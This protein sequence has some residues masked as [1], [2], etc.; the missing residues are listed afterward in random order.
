[1]SDLWDSIPTWVVVLAA[2]LILGALYVVMVPV[3]NL[4]LWMFLL[5]FGG[6]VVGGIVGL[7]RGLL[8][9]GL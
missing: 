3:M 5:V 8:G 1:M 4:P 2:L 6:I 9:G 7:V